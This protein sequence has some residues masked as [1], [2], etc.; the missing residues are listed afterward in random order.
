MKI[1]SRV[2]LSVICTVVAVAQQGPP[3]T[4]AP[5]EMKALAQLAGEW[6]GGGWH[7][8]PAGRHE[9]RQTEKVRIGTRGHTLIIEGHGTLATTGET[10]HDALAVISWDASRDRYRVDAW[11]A[12]GT[13]IEAS[14]RLEGDAF[15]WG[16]E[17]DKGQMRFTI[18]LSDPDR[19][20]EIGEFSRD[21][22]RWMQGISFELERASR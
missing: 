8:G 5:D 20:S 14:G 1:L 16:F 7:S 13:Y 19:W 10:V 21:G 9:F 3:V 11:K 12:D 17:T 22:K 4:P 6:E 2:L 18:D 15:I